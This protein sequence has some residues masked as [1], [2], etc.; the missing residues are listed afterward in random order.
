MQRT[1]R[2][3]LPVFVL[4]LLFL[5]A[6]NLA[7][8]NQAASREAPRRLLLAVTRAGDAG[9]TEEELAVVSRS[10]L[11]ALQEARTD[12]VMVEPARTGQDLSDDGMSLLAEESA[13]DCWMLVE[14]S[15]AEEEP[16]FRVRSR[17]VL[18]GSTV[19]DT[20]LRR[21]AGE[22]ISVMSLPYERWD[23]LS[24]LISGA[25]PPREAADMPVRDRGSALLTV[26]ALPGTILAFSGGTQATVGP[27][28]TSEVTL[29]V[30]A[31]Y[32]LRAAHAGSASVLRTLFIQSDRELSIEQAPVSRFAVDV[33]ALICWP[34]LAVSFFPVPER[35][36]VRAGL[37]TYLVGLALR[38]GEVFSSD[39][40]TNLDL[41]AGLYFSPGYA[42]VRVYA[43]FGGF[44]R[45]VHAPESPM[46][47]EPLAP[48][49]FA[50][51][52]GL[53]TRIGASVRFFAEY[54][55]MLYRTAAPELLR[56]T[57]RSSAGWVFSYDAAFQLLSFRIG[58][59]WPL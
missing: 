27:D 31:A 17:D 53:E 25:Y 48:A 3:A 8:Q 12:L 39:P 59:R 16:V 22:K 15:G 46:R 58:M 38:P 56:S 21:Q 24:A 41:L 43:A 7:G 29:P 6:A 45:F 13:A 51:A 50:T 4:S 20:S 33:S 42:A 32:E 36:F 28:G 52:L 40:L 57:L 44:L 1:C 11:L 5:A 34:G 55:P 2:A 19:I 47:I 26:R 49:G 30:P 10:M 35:M 18:S 37:T 23:D 9:L 14:I 54:E